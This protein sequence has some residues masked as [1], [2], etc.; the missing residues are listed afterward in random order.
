MQ[1]LKSLNFSGVLS[2]I[3]SALL[4]V[5]F[6]L[7]GIVIFS[8][9]LKFVD[10]SSSIISYV[11]DIIKAISIFL[12]ALNIKR[13]NGEKFLIKTIFSGVVYAL[14]SFII[15]SIFNGNFSLNLSFLFDLL[16]ALA[17]SF[18]VAIIINVLNRK[19]V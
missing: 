13:K 15:F 17:V 12:M 10:I 3:K 14:L 7:I 16:F 11:N 6:T 19:A 9:V 8:V 4:G 18:I 5:I 1:K 2:I